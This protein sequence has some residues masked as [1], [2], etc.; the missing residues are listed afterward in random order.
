MPGVTYVRSQCVSLYSSTALVAGLANVASSYLD[1]RNFGELAIMRTSTTGTYAFEIDWS[2]DGTNA[3]LTETITT[4]D[5]VSQRK[6]VMAPYAK[7][8][9]K[10]THATDAFTA[11]YTSVCGVE[12]G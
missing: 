1:V 7:I 5:K 8:R 4:T 12:P 10:N 6:P 2:L 11:H 9:V 3:I